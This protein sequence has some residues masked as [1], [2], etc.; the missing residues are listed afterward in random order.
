MTTSHLIYG[1]RVVRADLGSESG[2][3]PAG[4]AGVLAGQKRQDHLPHRGGVFYG[5]LPLLAGDFTENP[6][7]TVTLFNAQGVAT[8]PP[9]VYQNFYEAFKENGTQIY[10]SGNS[11]GSTPFN[12]TWNAELDQELRPD[13][14]ARVS[15]LASRTYDEFIVN[16]VDP[17]A[18]AIPSCCSRTKGAPAIMNLKPPCACG[19]RKRRISASPTLIASRAAT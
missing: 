5:R 18:A 6:T 13:V 4:R 15:Y 14:I 8:G 1:V 9:T 7:R 2:W 17:G 19:R 3:F 16:P 11:L 10:P 12:I